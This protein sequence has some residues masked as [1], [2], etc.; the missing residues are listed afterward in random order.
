M[1][2]AEMSFTDTFVYWLTHSHWPCVTVAML[3]FLKSSPLGSLVPGVILLPAIGS[4]SAHEQVGF[5]YL[6][7]CAMSGAMLADSL[8]YWLGRL[9]LSEWRRKLH[10]SDSNHLM[11]RTQTLFRKY[12]LFAIF[13]GRV[14]WFIHPLVPVV[15]GVLGK[16]PLIFYVV[17]F[18]AVLLWL[19]FYMSGGYWLGVLWLQLDPRHHNWFIAILALVILGIMA[20]TWSR[21][22]HG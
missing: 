8:G 16:R 18:S 10:W 9:R 7:S 11:Q 19:L 6:M 2:V 14:M 12:G 17:D 5:W 20:F 1:I 13:I 15:A 3:L 22:R 21:R 4:L